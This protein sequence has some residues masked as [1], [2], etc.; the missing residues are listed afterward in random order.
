MTLVDLITLGV[1]IIGLKAALVARKT[2]LLV[3]G[4]L[5]AS[6]RWMLPS[7]PVYA[8]SFTILLVRNFL[9]RY[10]VFKPMFSMNFD[11]DVAKWQMSFNMKIWEPII[12]VLKNVQVL[13]ELL[14]LVL[15]LIGLI[16]QYRLFQELSNEQE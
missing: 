16:R 8:T 1:A 2:W 6:W 10:V 4:D 12:L 3:E 7:V 13:V 9:Q 11:L 5:A 14:F 15:V